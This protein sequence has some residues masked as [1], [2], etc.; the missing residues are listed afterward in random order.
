MNSLT[1]TPPIIPIDNNSTDSSFMTDSIHFYLSYEYLPLKNISNLIKNVDELYETI[2]FTLYNEKV[3]ERYRLCLNYATTGN[4]IDW[5]GKLIDAVKPSRGAMIALSIAAA[6]IYTP[7]GLADYKK[8][9]ADIAKTTAET[10]LKNAEAKKVEL[11]NEKTIYNN[12]VAERNIGNDLKN[13]LLNDSKRNKILK[14][15]KAIKKM[16]IYKSINKVIVNN[17][18]VIN[19]DK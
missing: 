1:T 19:R 14:K 7:I 11:E 17:T 8:K 2:Y 3:P 5:I 12:L 15:N 10:R 6:I 4:S 13:R 18:I 9:V 16:I